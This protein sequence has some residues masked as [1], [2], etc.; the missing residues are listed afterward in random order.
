MRQLVSAGEDVNAADPH[1][2]LPIHT[3][4]S[5]DRDRVVAYLVSAGSELEARGADGWTPL[6]L[7]CV[8][9]SHRAVGALIDGGADVNAVARG[10]NTPLH[11][12]L[13]V[14]LGKEYRELRR[15]AVRCARRMI[16]RLL[17]AGADPR[18]LDSRGRR[19]ADVACE[20]AA[21]TLASLLE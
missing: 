15:Q 14:V 3:A 12:A 9:G 19:A 10:G 11:L 5:H 21:A 1:G 4:A 13:V 8:S 16:E 6:H 17:A 2:R 7:A 18:A 20:K